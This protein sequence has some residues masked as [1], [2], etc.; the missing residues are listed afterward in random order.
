ME[1][2]SSHFYGSYCTPGMRW[3]QVSARWAGVSVQVFVIFLFHEAIASYPGW[4]Y[5][6]PLIARAKKE[7]SSFGLGGED[8]ACESGS[9]LWWVGLGL[10]MW[11]SACGVGGA[12]VSRLGGFSV[13]L[14]QLGIQRLEEN[15]A[16]H[17]I[18]LSLQKAC[19]LARTSHLAS[20]L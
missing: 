4:P 8:R 3:Q 17:L 2:V 1:R 9:G 12:Y 7:E 14:Q 5:C 10:C 11:F 16:A 20:A 6:H 19:Q 13:G 18:A 15:R